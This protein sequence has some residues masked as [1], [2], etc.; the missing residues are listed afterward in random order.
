MNRCVNKLSPEIIDEE[1]TPEDAIQYIKKKAS[2]V[3]EMPEGFTI[4]GVTILGEGTL[5]TGLKIKKKEILFYFK[6][7]CFGTQLLKIKA[8]DADLEEIR[9]KGKIV[10]GK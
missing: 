1:I 9:T 10:S 7:P 6:K 3:Y 4:K 5:Y 8:D 2:E